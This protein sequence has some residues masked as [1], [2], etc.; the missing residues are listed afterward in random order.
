[1]VLILSLPHR[2][3]KLGGEEGK[4]EQEVRVLD[5]QEAKL[6]LEAVRRQRNLFP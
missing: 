4:T 2:E 5:W 6:S 3:R 1:M